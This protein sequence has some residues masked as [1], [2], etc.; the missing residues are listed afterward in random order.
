VSQADPRSDKQGARLDLHERAA[1]LLLHPTSLPGPFETGDLGTAA[2][3]FVDFL[4]SAGLSIWQMLPLGPV[5]P[6][7]SPYSATSVFAGSP[8]LV[9]LERLAADG[10]LSADD[11]LLA[12]AA[13]ASVAD[14]GRSIERRR[15]ALRKAFQVAKTRPDLLRGAKEFS[16]RHAYWLR[17]FALFSTL[18]EL[19][20]GASHHA[21]PAPLRLREPSALAKLAHDHADDVAFHEFVQYRFATDVAA[22]R[23]KAASRGVS[24][25]GDAP[26]YVAEDSVEVW[27]HPEL[28]L[29]DDK[30]ELASVAGV[31][32]DAFSDDGQLWGNPLYDWDYLQKSGFG[33]W[34]ARIEHALRSVDAIRLDHFIGFVRYYAIP[35]GEKS[36][37]R[38]TYHSVPGRA[39]F[40]ALRAALGPIPLVAEDL[41]VVTDEVHALRDH[42]GFPGMGILQFS[43]SPDPGAESSRPH[44]YR[45]RSVVYTG[46]HDNDTTA[47]WFSGPPDDA[48]ADSRA[49]WARERALAIEYVGLPPA[50]TDAELAWGLVREAM[51]SH[52]VLSVVPMQDL[53]G[54]G[55]EHR[56]N[57]PGIAEGNWA[58]R[59]LP[60]QATAELAARVRK[61]V[62]LYGR[63]R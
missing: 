49:R 28:F 15:A 55:R 9:S 33:F 57:R 10:L 14:Y 22:L 18:K 13:P 16:D 5:G 45:T 48:S 52:A 32:P 23:A 12:P 62:E 3:A 8:W 59:M 40:D 21:W 44:R 1:G 51:K 46:T 56:M 27:A 4:A 61:L 34:V 36:A 17:D 58:Y 53:L 30:G 47:G 6:G 38:G 43:F 20:G 41:G 7:N 50:G 29:R 19:H 25:L 37:K 11:P 2:H 24:M 35:R 63:R 31:P 60:G 26:I 39:L 42:F 54:Q